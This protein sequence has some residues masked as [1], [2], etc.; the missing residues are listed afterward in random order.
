MRMITIL[1][2]AA[3]VGAG[4]VAASAAS[5]TKSIDVN[6]SPAAVWEAIGPF[7]SIKDW[8]PAIGQ[9]TTDGKTPPTRTL[10]TKDGTATFVELETGR[11]D[12]HHS[13]S[14]EIE[15]SPL[16]LSHYK[17]RISVSSNGTGGSTI[18]WKSHFKP[19][20]GK[21]DAASEAVA[22]VYQ[23]GLDAVKAKFAK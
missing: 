16:P 20:E 15:S 22:G 1:A 21:K 5:V 3:L 6:A 18:I 9:C 13:Y 12:K 23:A 4:T 10:V 2:A 19:A 17:S 7:C 14:Y 8:H 11:S